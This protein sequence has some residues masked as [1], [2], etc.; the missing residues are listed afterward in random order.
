MDE[1]GEE[2]NHGVRYLIEDPIPPYRIGAWKPIGT[3][4]LGSSWGGSEVWVRAQ[5]EAVAKGTIDTGM[6]T[7]FLFCT[8]RSAERRKKQKAEDDK[9]LESFTWMEMPETVVLRKASLTVADARELATA[10]SS[11]NGNG[12]TTK[13]TIAE[14]KARCPYNTSFSGLEF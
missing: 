2:A 8:D 12:S 6:G 11:A 4:D 10:T 14:L 3:S 1:Y 5:G 13:A 7:Q 9:E